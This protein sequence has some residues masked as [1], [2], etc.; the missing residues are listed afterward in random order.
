MQGN[1]KKTDG[2]WNHR[3]SANLNILNVVWSTQ[4][5][6]AAND[7]NNL[8]KV[9]VVLSQVTSHNLTSASVVSSVN[10]MTRWQ[11][12][13]NLHNTPQMYTSTKFNTLQPITDL[14]AANFFA[15][16]SKFGQYIAT[17]SQRQSEIYITLLNIHSI[18]LLDIFLKKNHVF[19]YNFYYGCN[20]YELINH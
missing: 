12:D 20:D 2:R 11:N 3:C 14:L 18:I 9:R 17:L 15:S 7:N 19:M 5:V 16:Y 4:S 13:S 8:S 6:H 1:R 10:Q